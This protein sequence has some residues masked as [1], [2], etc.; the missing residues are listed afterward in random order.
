MNL[1]GVAQIL[2]ILLHHC[3]LQRLHEITC[4]KL[5][6]LWANHNFCIK[7]INNK[8]RN[9]DTNVLFCGFLRKA[10]NFFI[11]GWHQYYVASS[12]QI[13]TGNYLHKTTSKVKCF[14]F[15]SRR[16]LILLEG[17]GLVSIHG[18][19]FLNRCFTLN[20]LVWDSSSYLQAQVPESIDWR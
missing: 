18:T 3:W 6:L 1:I 2:G 7:L 19:D 4:L 17:Y 16:E 15:V 14:F 13:P 10:N 12:T 9:S 5:P 8:E 20:C 11:F